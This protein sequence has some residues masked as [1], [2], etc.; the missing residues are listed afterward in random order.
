MVGASM[1]GI[2]CRH[3]FRTLCSFSSFLKTWRRFLHW[4]SSYTCAQRA[5][6][7]APVPSLH[8]STALDI[9]QAAVPIVF[10][11]TAVHMTCGYMWHISGSQWRCHF[12]LQNAGSTLDPPKCAARCSTV[13]PPAK[14]SQQGQRKS[15]WTEWT[16]NK[17]AECC[18]HASKLRRARPVTFE[19]KA[20]QR[21]CRYT[22]VKR[23]QTQ[24][25]L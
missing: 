21:S 5:A 18:L 2:S 3:H 6:W 23:C 14:P 8:G 25:L 9:S 12:P 10:P 24:S 15:E 16:W 20:N 4:T 17:A 11:G 19:R 1:A 7:P 22:K 13:D